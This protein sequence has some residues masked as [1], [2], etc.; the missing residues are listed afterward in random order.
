MRTAEPL[1]F[2]N[3]WVTDLGE[4]QHK[5]KSQPR[6]PRIRKDGY[7][8]AVLLHHGRKVGVY[9][10]RLV[11]E[12]FNGPLPE[13][14]QINHKDGDK[15]NNALSNLEAI[16]PS[17]NSKHAYKEGLK[18]PQKEIYVRAAKKRRKITD[19][20]AT[21]M[22]AMRK[23]GHSLRDIGRCFDVHHK[24]VSGVVHQTSEFRARPDNRNRAW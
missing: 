3:Y 6:K 11:Y 9:I 22:C 19:E 18:I 24:S 1:G 5:R 17:D 4:L 15:G 14:L 7:A 23:A 21:A 20:Q 12:A 2:S 16:T 10:H 8:T 13:G